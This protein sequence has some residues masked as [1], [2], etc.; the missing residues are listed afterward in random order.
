MNSR[1]DSKPVSTGS[2]SSTI[3]IIGGIVALLVVAAGTV[4]I[5]SSTDNAATPTSVTVTSVNDQGTVDTVVLKQT[6]P[7]Q[8]A[9]GGLPPLGDSTGAG[10]PAFGQQAP[11]LVGKSFDGSPVTVSPGKATL[12]V[13][14]AHWCP[15]CQREVPRLVSWF[16]LGQVP[17]G[18][19]VIGVATATTTTRDNY[20]PSVW[21]QRE[22][23][24]WPILADSDTQTAATAFGL[25][26]FPFFV[27]V[28]AT[29]KVVLRQ[30]GEVE[31]A[32]L[33]AKI[34]A[35]LGN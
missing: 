4:A 33:T 17:T 16:Q 24:P 10:D 29:G 6:Q 28:D 32:D 3:W 14:L 31:T 12:I 18:L 22:T 26:S 23:F 34:N 20:P 19:D 9:G 13:F 35:A 11:S 7:V 15:H 21:L 8:V 25:D 30:A 1:Q 2:S 27:L 5:V